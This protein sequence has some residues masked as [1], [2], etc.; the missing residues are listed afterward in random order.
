MWPQIQCDSKGCEIY[1]CKNTERY[2]HFSV[3]IGLCCCD[4]L[5]FRG[6]GALWCCWIYYRV[7]GCG[8]RADVL[9]SRS[10]LCAVL[11]NIFTALH[12]WKL[13]AVVFSFCSVVLW[14]L[15]L[16]HFRIT[17]WN[18]KS[19]R[20]E[21]NNCHTQKGLRLE[22]F[23]EYF[24]SQLLWVDLLK[25]QSFYT[26]LIWILKNDHIHHTVTRATPSTFLKDSISKKF[27]IQ[28]MTT[29]H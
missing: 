28:K 6:V 27:G 4:L 5:S 19:T 17:F 12:N 3:Y 15:S 1:F 8:L 22:Y 7:L 21:K 18:Y 10:A 2:V 16:K 13:G 20:G 11:K 14:K 29:P 25:K 9:C 23:E 26:F 24:L